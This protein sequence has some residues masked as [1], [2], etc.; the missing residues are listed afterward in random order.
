MNT[1]RL[2][3]VLALAC[4]LGLTGCG[5]SGEVRPD[6]L[7]ALREDPMATW[8]PQGGK[9]RDTWAHDARLGSSMSK[10]QEAML[11]RRITLPDAKARNRALRE[12]VSFAER[13]GWRLLSQHHPGAVLARRAPDGTEAILVVTP[14]SDG[15]RA[16]T[17]E[18]R[19]GP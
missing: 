9:L 8:V 15:D 13:S 6:H 14:A 10:Q 16:L 2:A 11:L 19:V 1:Q 17:V 7:V 12:G 3:A 5:M 4:A 18:L